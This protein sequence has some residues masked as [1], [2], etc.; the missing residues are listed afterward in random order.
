MLAQVEPKYDLARLQYYR[1]AAA[2][3]YSQFPFAIA[4]VLAEVP[5]AI[6]CAVCFFLPLYYIPG[7]QPEASRAGYQFFMVLL[8][9]F[10]STTL[11]QMLAAV[12]P[13]SFIAALLNPFIINM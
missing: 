7:L 5:Y 1:E 10:F 3:S 2:K 9:S 13:S 12:T 11:G 6:I 8:T 4:M